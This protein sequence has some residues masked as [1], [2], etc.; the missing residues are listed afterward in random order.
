VVDIPAEG[1]DT[2]VLLDQAISIVT[3]QA[4]SGNY[5][6]VIFCRGF[7]DDGNFFIY[8][9]TQFFFQTIIEP[10]ECVL[11]MWK[12]LTKCC[13]FDGIFSLDGSSISLGDCLYFKNFF[14]NPVKIFFFSFRIN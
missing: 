13:S 8:M 5:M 10:M 11:R 2:A 12:R 7:F 14:Q 9:V 6:K 4:T 3:K 1:S